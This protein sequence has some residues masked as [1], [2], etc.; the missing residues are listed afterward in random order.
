MT[1]RQSSSYRHWPVEIRESDARRALH[2]SVNAH[3]DDVWHSVWKR[4]EDAG[5]I[6]DHARP[7]RRQPLQ[8]PLDYVADRG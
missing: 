5:P 7:A 3:C 2:K 1:P 8:A 6:R 4:I